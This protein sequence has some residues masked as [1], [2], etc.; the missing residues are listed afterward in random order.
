MKRMLIIG[1][2]L[3]SISVYAQDSTVRKKAWTFSGYLKDLA[4]VRFEKDFTNAMATNLVHN[5]MNL[6]WNPD[7]HWNARLELRNRFYWGDDVRTVPDFKQQLGN[8]N[9]M[10]NLSSTWSSGSAVMVSNIERFWMEYK[11]SKWNIRAGRQR[12]NWGITNTW[13]PN[14]LFNSYNFL[15]FDYEE[16]PGSDAV[17]GQYL[18]N[19]LSHIELAVAGTRHQSIMAV[20]YSL[21]YKKYD[22]QANAGVYQNIATA[23]IGWDGSIGNIGFKGEAQFYG[24]RKEERSQILLVLEADYIF[25]NAWYL[26]SAFLFNEKGLHHPLNDWAKLQFQASPRYLMPTRWNVLVNTTKEFTPLLNGSFSLVYAPGVNLLILYPSVR[27][28]LKTNLDLNL[29]WQSFF[30]ETLR[31]EALSHTGFLRLKWSF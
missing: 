30:A 11:R 13:N 9:E 18:V 6:K 17:K 31:F 7:E 2:V 3:L 14:D 12:I 19:D 27:Y 29:V 26:S 21:N 28:N 24:A 5:R 25:E 23:G 1:S 15:D 8:E 16:R 4:W 10:V 22:L 20:K